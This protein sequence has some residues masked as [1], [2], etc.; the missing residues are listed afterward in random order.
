MAMARSDRFIP[1]VAAQT[2]TCGF[3]LAISMAQR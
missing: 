3:L 1:F 2:P